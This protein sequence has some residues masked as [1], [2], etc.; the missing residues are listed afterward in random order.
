MPWL[1]LNWHLIATYLYEEGD[2]L[3][4][5]G[6]GTTISKAGKSSYGLGR[7]FSSIVGRPIKGLSFFSYSIVNVTRR[8]SFPMLMRQLTKA[9]QAKSQVKEKQEESPKRGRGRPKGSKNKNRRDIEL[10][11]LNQKLQNYLREVLSVIGERVKIKFCLLDGAFGNNASI[12]MV[13]QCGLHIVSK[14]NRRAAL[15]LPF[16]GEQ[17]KRGAP[18][19]YGDKINYDS[20]PLGK[21]VSSSIERGI[22]TW[23]YQFHA[24]HRKIA[25]KLN[26]V[27]IVKIDH[28]T[29]KRRHIVLFSTDLSLEWEKLIDLYSLRFQIEFNFREAKQF[30]GLEDFMNI[31]STQISNASNLAM[32]MVNISHILW[33]RLPI[34]DGSTHDLKTLFRGQLYAQHLLK[35]LPEPLDSLLID[36][37]LQDICSLGAIHPH[38]P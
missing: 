27:V 23:V 1:K 18:R 36:R 29:G 34:T 9:D 35:F 8:R 21:R 2:E 26:I 3:A 20:L 24:W 38:E 30:W 10:S 22:E 19:K 4:I 33:Q 37:F 5:A 28:A 25:D 17:K 31:K 7:Y 11:L 16:S 32:F 14:L 15:F 6:D 13:R 12:Q